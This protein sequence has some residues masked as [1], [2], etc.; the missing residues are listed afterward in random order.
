MSLPK[1]LLKHTL[2]YTTNIIDTLIN[3]INKPPSPDME[4][5][6]LKVFLGKNRS[7]IFRSIKF[8]VNNKQLNIPVYKDGSKFEIFNQSGKALIKVSKLSN[9]AKP[10]S[11]FKKPLNDSKDFFC[12]PS[13]EPGNEYAVAL[14]ASLVV[15]GSELVTVIKPQLKSTYNELVEDE[16]EIEAEYN[17]LYAEYYDQV[18]EGL[19]YL[20][21]NYYDEIQSQIYNEYIYYY[22]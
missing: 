1:Q 4:F 2:D 20:Y 3:T 11:E 6:N 5:G 19:T 12:K 18:S 13:G 16:P 10:K 15:V 7:G 17:D 9:T 21:S 14:L 22:G 8:V